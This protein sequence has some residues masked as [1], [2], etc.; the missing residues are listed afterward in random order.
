[1]GLYFTIKNANG[2]SLVSD[3]SGV[4][5]QQFFSTVELLQLRSRKA[6]FRKFSRENWEV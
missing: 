4:L 1:M 2:K 3:I 6:Q 5:L